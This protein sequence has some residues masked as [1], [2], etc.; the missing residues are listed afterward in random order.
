MFSQYNTGKPVIVPILFNLVI[1]E[2]RFLKYNKKYVWV[3]VK[4]SLLWGYLKSA[5]TGNILGTLST[6]SI[7]MSYMRTST[8]HWRVTQAPFK[9]II[10]LRK[11]GFCSL[12]KFFETQHYYNLKDR[13]VF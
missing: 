13:S 1:F 3:T 10:C 2:L 5:S 6:F 4:T 11:F 7:D 12:L 9:K 8:S